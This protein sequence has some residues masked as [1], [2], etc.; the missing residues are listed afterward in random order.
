MKI[1]P[2]EIRAIPG[3]ASGY[4]ANAQ[5]EIFSDWNP[6]KRARD[7]KLRKLK[8]WHTNN[9]YLS[10]VIAR[11]KTRR[12]YLVHELILRSFK[13]AKKEA[14]VT[15]H[16][17]GNKTNNF[18]ENLCWGTRSENE[19]DKKAHGRSNDGERNG[20]VKLRLKDVEEI[21]HLLKQ[22]VRQS[23]IASRFGIAQCT[24]SDI[25]TRRRW[26]NA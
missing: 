13:R 17:D 22:G 15:R 18:I 4:F 10:V 6:G 12:T 5:G 16:L 14:E 2:N 3:V 24:V 20:M 1:K 23:K 8:L 21:K 19:R 11:N 9:G 26:S 25:N 7:K